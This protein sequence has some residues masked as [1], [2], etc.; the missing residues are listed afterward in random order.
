MLA[1]RKVNNCRNPPL[2]LFSPILTSTTSSS[3]SS[4]CV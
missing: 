3:P 1:D 4:T 2:L